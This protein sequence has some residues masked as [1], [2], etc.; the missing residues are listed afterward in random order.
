MLLDL[1]PPE[2]ATRNLLITAILY[3]NESMVKFLLEQKHFKNLVNA[4]TAETH[5]D[6]L[7]IAAKQGYSRIIRI[8]LKNGADIRA[9]NVLG[10]TLLINLVYCDL[11]ITIE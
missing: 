1:N 5:W 6:P 3:G 11:K 7:M 10:T 9:K 2:S 4:K 8:L